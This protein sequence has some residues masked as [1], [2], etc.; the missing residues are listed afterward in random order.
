[1]RRTLLAALARAAA[2]ACRGALPHE[3]AALLPPLHGAECRP[4]RLARALTRRGT[5]RDSRRVLAMRGAARFVAGRRPRACAVA[6]AAGR[7]RRRRA[8]QS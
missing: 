6:A 8:A 2:P 4:Q 5:P 7:R 1:M 3:H